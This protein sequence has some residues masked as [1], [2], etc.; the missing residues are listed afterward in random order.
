MCGPAESGTVH[1]GEQSLFVS[2]GCADEEEGLKIVPVVQEL[3]RLSARRTLQADLLQNAEERWARW[4]NNSQ[5][6]LLIHGDRMAS[7]LRSDWV[8]EPVLAQRQYLNLNRPSIPMGKAIPQE[9]LMRHQRWMFPRF[10]SSLPKWMFAWI[11]KSNQ[12]LNV[13]RGKTNTLISLYQ[14]V[15]WLFLCD[16]HPVLHNLVTNRQHMQRHYFCIY[17]T[18]YVKA[19]KW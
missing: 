18:D 2:P 17:V 4:Q 7:R 6:I 1:K 12:L 16:E 11:S 19:A 9:I 14:F 15:G 13:F 3:H 8:G 5:W 10:I